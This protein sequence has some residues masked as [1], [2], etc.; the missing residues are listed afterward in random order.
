MEGRGWV[1]EDNTSY[2]NVRRRRREEG[3]SATERDRLVL[4]EI[5][6]I[7]LQLSTAWGSVHMHLVL[8]CTV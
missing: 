4:Y 6:H 8:Y 5:R 1:S 2:M 3:R 7:H